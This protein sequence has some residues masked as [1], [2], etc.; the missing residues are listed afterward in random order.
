MK[1][2]PSP[3]GEDRQP[4]EGEAI[5]ISIQNLTTIAENF[6]VIVADA[7]V[8]LAEI[9]RRNLDLGPDDAAHVDRLIAAF[10]AEDVEAGG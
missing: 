9:M 1:I 2:Y 4:T 10:L 6:S 5:V 3:D 8:S 7:V